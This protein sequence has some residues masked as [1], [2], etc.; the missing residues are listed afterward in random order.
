MTRTRA[1]GFR[2]GSDTYTPSITRCVATCH[3]SFDLID[4]FNGQNKSITAGKPYSPPVF[5]ELLR[6]A[7]FKRPS[8]LG[9]KICK[10]FE[11]SLPDKPDEKEL[12]ASLLALVATA[13]RSTCISCRCDLLI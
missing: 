11:S 13:V 4:P 2:K 9:F 8:S 12:P 3:V 5:L 7:F 10:Y 6:V 1:T